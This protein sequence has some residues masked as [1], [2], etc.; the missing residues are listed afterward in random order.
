MVVAKEPGSQNDDIIFDK[1]DITEMMAEVDKGA[2][3]EIDIE[4]D[5]IPEKEKDALLE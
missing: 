1:R 5:L 4:A 3:A 2:E